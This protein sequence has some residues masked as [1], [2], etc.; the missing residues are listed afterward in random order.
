MGAAE[1]V[2]DVAEFVKKFNDIELNRRIL[3][4]EEEVIDLTR[5]KRRADEK[6][7]QLELQLKFRGTL[8]FNEPFYWING[9]K[10]PFC[11]TCWEGNKQAVHVI[12]SH[13]NNNGEWWNCNVCK[14]QYNTRG[15]R[16]HESQFWGSQ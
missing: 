10:V 14:T 3:K 16:H 6:I 5:D 1:Y 11:P 4:L 8:I 7:E 9:D 13:S 12:Y 15:V 2:K